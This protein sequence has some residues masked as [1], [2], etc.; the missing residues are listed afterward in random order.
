MKLLQDLR[1]QQSQL[2]I[3]GLLRLQVFL[4]L[5][6][7]N[8]PL[9]APDDQAH[10]LDPHL[11]EEPL[12]VSVE[13]GSSGEVAVGFDAAVEELSEEPYDADD[14]AYCFGGHDVS[15]SRAGAVSKV[16]LSFISKLMELNYRAISE[17]AL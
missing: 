11:A 5:A 17:Y 16:G 6:L 14:G 10:L 7:R 9:A 15:K 4:Q 3:S 1:S 2:R 12:A 8:T 13:V